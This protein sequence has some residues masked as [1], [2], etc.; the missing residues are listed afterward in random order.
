MLEVRWA[1]SFRHFP[2]T[3]PGPTLAAA[4]HLAFP[5]EKLASVAQRSQR[6]DHAIGQFIIGTQFFSEQIPSAMLIERILTLM[7]IVGFGCA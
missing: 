4:L 5:P 3:K 2:K 7:E 6:H 1:L